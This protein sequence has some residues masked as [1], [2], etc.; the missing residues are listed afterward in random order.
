[1]LDRVEAT[2]AH[3]D[4]LGARFAGVKSDIVT[5]MEELATEQDEVVRLS[6]SVLREETEMDSVK[7]LKRHFR[8]IGALL[9]HPPGPAS[10]T[11][12]ISKFRKHA[13]GQELQKK[14]KGGKTKKS[15]IGTYG[16]D[17][18]VQ[19]ESVRGYWPMLMQDDM[20]RMKGV[21]V[22]SSDAVEV[23]SPVAF[24]VAENVMRKIDEVLSWSKNQLEEYQSF[25]EVLGD[26]E[27][28]MPDIPHAPRG[29]R[30]GEGVEEENCDHDEDFL[31]SKN[32]KS[33]LTCFSWKTS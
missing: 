3:A 1:L 27:T 4:D 13:K 25:V 18:F 16:F 15:E 5:W 32:Q 31:E 12:H 22:K 8:T 30:R 28:P 29:L 23:D 19:D 10:A 14:V 21:V 24:D 7:D 2:H 9:S 33:L 6:V 26:M 17:S 20:R 11:R